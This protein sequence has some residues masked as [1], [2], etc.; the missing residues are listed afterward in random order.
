MQG[1]LFKPNR[2][3]ISIIFL[4]FDMYLNGKRFNKLGEFNYIYKSFNVFCASN[5]FVACKLTI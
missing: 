5:P 1:Y 3:K 4:S 2:F